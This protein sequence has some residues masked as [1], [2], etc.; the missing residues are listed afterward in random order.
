MAFPYI[1]E[2]NFEQG[3]NGEWDSESDTGSKLSFPHYSQLARYDASVIGP[4]APFRGAYAA[5]WDLGDTNDHTLIE[6]D[7]DIADGATRY[8]RFYLFLGKDLRCTADDTFPIFEHQGTANAVEASLGLRMT[9]STGTV[10]IGVGFTVPTVFAASALQRGRWYCVELLTTISTGVSGLSTLFLD[11]SQV[12]TITDLTNTAVLR[13][14]LGSQDTT[15]TTLGH[16]FID[17][18]AFDDTRLSPIT[19]RYPEALMMT[20]STHIAV[21]ETEILNLTLIPGSGTNCVVKLYDTDVAYTADENNSPAMLMNLTASEPPIDLADV[22]MT[23]KRGAYAEISGTGTRVL[24]RIGRSMGYGSVGRI[25]DYG[26][27]RK[28]HPIAD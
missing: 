1:F 17:Q 16:I 24:S 20:K 22:P 15:A 6:G 7:I 28:N 26:N 27:K 8:L 2:S 9:A 23:F 14:V 13:G 19:D 11:G 3:T 10:E 25:R 5:E 18:F 21:G 4:I 12:A